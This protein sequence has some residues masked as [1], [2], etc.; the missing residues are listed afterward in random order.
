MEKFVSKLINITGR[1]HNIEIV[2]YGLYAIIDGLETI[3]VI[4]LLGVVTGKMNCSL[5]Y[6]LMSFVGTGT[7]GGV[8]L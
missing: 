4:I 3:T 6:L 8:S 7:M 2:T 1:Q 5:I